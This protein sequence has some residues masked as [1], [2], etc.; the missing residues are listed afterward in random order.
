MSKLKKNEET[1]QEPERALGSPDQPPVPQAKT[2]DP[3]SASGT[4]Q[5]KQFP[6]LSANEAGE[7][8]ILLTKAHH[9][10]ELDPTAVKRMG[11]LR[12]KA[13]MAGQKIT[14]QQCAKCHKL[15]YAVE[16]ATIVG[17]HICAKRM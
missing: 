15:Y 8:A 9:V 3:A 2:P 13:N 11:A 10:R 4:P 5:A 6:P 7:L 16:G 17:C 14:P 1:S 12:D